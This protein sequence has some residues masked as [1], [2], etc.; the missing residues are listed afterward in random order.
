MPTTFGKYTV[1]KKLGQGGMGAVYLALDPALNRRVA[2]KVIT[3]TDPELLERF[4]REASA[5]AKLKHPNIV[6][7]YEAGIVPTGGSAL[8]KQHYF[9]MDYIE[10]VSLDALIKSKN[11][12]SLQNLVKI[13]LQTATALHY[14]HSQGIIHRDIKPA[15]IMITK[16]GQAYITDFGLAK[17]LTGLDRSLTLTGTTIG[18]PDYMPP[19]QAMG[20]K[21]QI[22]PRSDIFSLGATLYH[23][24]TGRTPFSG[25]EL[26][27][28][29]NKVI[30][31][32]P[33]TPS[34]IIKII[35]KDLETICLKCL[36][37]D[38]TR[39]YQTAD[40]LAQD[41]KRYLEGGQITAKRTSYVSKL[42]FRFI[43][44]KT[45]SLSILGAAVILAIVVTS[46]LVSSSNK[47][48]LIARYRQEAQQ[49]FDK[50]KYDQA[51]TISNKLLVLS[52]DDEA[53]KDI[54]NKSE[55][56][57]NER[58]AKKQ[59]EDAKIKEA[60]VKEQKIVD[61][62]AQ[63]KAVLDKATVAPTPDQKIQFAQDALAID[64][65]FGD[66]WQVIGYVYKG[67]AKLENAANE[68]YRN[69]MDKAFEYFSK[70]IKT[71]PTLAYSYYER[72]L[73]TLFTR[74]KPD[75]AMPDFQK[76]IELDPNSHIGWFSQGNI[77]S[78]KAQYDEG[79]QNY[80]KAIELYPDY[81][82]AYT[83]RGTCYA[84]KAQSEP[85]TDIHR[86]L[87]DKALADY[88]K[89]IELNRSNVQAYCNR[90][91]TYNE[92][93]QLDK[94]IADY[95]QAIKLDS[96][97]IEAYR[98]R[99]SAYNKKIESL[100]GKLGADAIQE[101]VAKAIADYDTIIGLNPNAAEA[102]HGRGITY[103]INGQLDKA[104][105]DYDQAIR[106]NP[107]YV[108][109]YNSRGTSYGQK[110]ETDKA[111]ADYN[112][113]VRLNP[114]Y[115]P[116]HYNRGDIYYD[117]GELDK[118]IEDYAAAVRLRYP[119]AYYNLALSHYEKSKMV[120]RPDEQKE[121][122][123][124]AIADGEMFL[125]LVPNHPQAN[126]MKQWVEEWKKQLAEQE[127]K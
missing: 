74:N 109:A 28:V 33:T 97:Y 60:A 120:S 94:A 67:K 8:N 49:A 54:L 1:E 24:I 41:L 29:L 115:A 42:R 30:N 72:A 50:E 127:K 121:L 69:L 91:N 87:L 99:G 47:R 125:R 25:K 38:K 114:E 111:F 61:L 53:I 13:I 9:T 32:D 36:N 117:R 62:R 27:E 116:A 98:T 19:E 56:I 71:T 16:Q 21:D 45:A 89:V 12:T 123:D 105:A 37:K 66:A 106:L 78:K 81:E 86:E 6:Q 65:T 46:L 20:Q 59:Q 92:M 58:E 104:I 90:G 48:Q 113:A 43:K 35:P 39:R 14:A 68:T 124:K 84:Y 18:T 103:D 102:Y 80:T 51:R 17:Q 95:G 100:R 83:N 31:D 76:V 119:L 79:I 112:A 110:G 11:K 63:A 108:E 7:V 2:L 82:L 70:A 40:A 3:S 52:P 77:N 26:Y 122:M 101:L 10:G 96:G 4:Q 126:E 93:G 88:Q 5:V 57:I 118:A 34:S 64:P 23:C 15:N 44:N 85:D 55:Q 73:I 22:D 75:E 107:G